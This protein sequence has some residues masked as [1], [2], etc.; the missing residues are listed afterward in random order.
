MRQTRTSGL[1][2]G[3]GKRSHW[4]KPQRHRALPR[5][6]NRVI[7][8]NCVIEMPKFR[9]IPM[10]KAGEHTPNLTRLP[11]PTRCFPVLWRRR[12]EK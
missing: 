3:E 10:N 4:Q 7:D 6:Y 5:L 11:R 8:R 9:E 12:A 2:S 1:M